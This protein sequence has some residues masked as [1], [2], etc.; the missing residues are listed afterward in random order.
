MKSRARE[1]FFRIR[2]ARPA[3]LEPDPGPRRV[4][5]D[6]LRAAFSDGWAVE[7]ITADTLE[8]NPVDGTTQVQAWLAAIRRN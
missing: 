3:R 1:Q 5:A 2:P 8:I 7:S 6:E 4:R